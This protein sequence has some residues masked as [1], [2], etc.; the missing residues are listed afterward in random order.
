MPG[1]LEGFLN[2]MVK[3]SYLERQRSDVADVMDAAVTQ[4]QTQ[5]RRRGR[6]SGGGRAGA[7]EES[8]VWEWRWGSRAEAEVGE[9]RIAELISQLFLDPTAAPDG[10]N[11]AGANDDED[12]QAIDRDRLAKR[13]KV[14][15]ANIA[16]VAGSQLVD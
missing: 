1:T 4:A 16:S 14:L 13:R 11:A 6:T 3:Q 15:L 10:A 5:G 12:T 2:S 9:K 8:I 7:D